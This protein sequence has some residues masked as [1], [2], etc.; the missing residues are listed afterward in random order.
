MDT[1]T[2]KRHRDLLILNLSVCGTDFGGRRQGESHE[3]KVLEER[4]ARGVEVIQ[5]ERGVEERE[6]GI[7]EKE[8]EG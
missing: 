6:G 3:C 5:G 2:E 7:E 1:Q 8:S 4:E